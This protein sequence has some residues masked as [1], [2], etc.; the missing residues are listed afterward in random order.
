MKAEKLV[1]IPVFL[2]E[3]LKQN[4][5]RERLRNLSNMVLCSIKDEE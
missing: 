1:D 4:E 2:E 5:K 3:K